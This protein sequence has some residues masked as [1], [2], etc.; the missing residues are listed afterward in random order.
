MTHIIVGFLC[1]ALA[2]L[3]IGGG[4]LLVI[5]LVLACGM[6]QLTAQGVNL[7]FFLFSSG[8]A[9]LVHLMRRTLNFRLIAS[10]AICGCLGAV[11]G[12]FLAKNADPAFMRTAFGWLLIT[13]GVIS[14]CK[15]QR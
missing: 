12:S 7:T 13:S 3:G 4:G 9:M 11:A 6:E 2:G 5:W 10:L 8:A 1:A 14:L 15:R